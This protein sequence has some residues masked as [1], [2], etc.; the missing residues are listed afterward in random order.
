MRSIVLLSVCASCAYGPGSF[1]AWDHDFAGTRATVGCIDLSVSRHRDDRHAAV[2]GYSFG[3]RCNDSHTIDLEH[4]V[5][6][7]RT[8]QGDTRLVA[9]DPDREIVPLPL[10]GGASGAE[11]IAYHLT[12][13]DDDV[14]RRMPVCVDVSSVVHHEPAMWQCF[15]PEA[16][17]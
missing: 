8:P 16:T 7:A 15:G 5:V 4:A 14:A 9:Y 17:R 6:V 2:L 13:G 12:G 3:N 10:D 11:T 1:T